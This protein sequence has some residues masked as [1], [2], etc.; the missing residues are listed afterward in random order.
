MHHSKNSHFLCNITYVIKT[1]GLSIGSSKWLRAPIMLSS[2]DPHL[3]RYEMWNIFWWFK[4]STTRK[5][6]SSH[7]QKNFVSRKKN[8]FNFN[9]IIQNITNNMNRRNMN[10]QRNHQSGYFWTKTFAKTFISWKI[11]IRKFLISQH[12][13]VMSA[14]MKNVASA[15]LVSKVML[16]TQPLIG[17]FR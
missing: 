2:V 1:S 3:T 13:I 17:W 5:L 10:N 8:N 15:S 9:Q 16:W 12:D 14:V 7:V 6:F 11:A 4:F